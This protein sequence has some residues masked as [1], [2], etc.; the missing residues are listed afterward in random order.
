MR[1]V[2][3]VRTVAT[4]SMAPAAQRQWPSIDLIEE[5]GISR[6]RFPSARLIAAVSA[7]SFCGVA[8]PCA[9]T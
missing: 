1:P 4:A 2:S 6:A 3:I 7:E 8:V 9:F 5:S